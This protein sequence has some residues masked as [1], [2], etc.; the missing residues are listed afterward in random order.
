MSEQYHCHIWDEPAIEGESGCAECP[1]CAAAVQGVGDDEYKYAL[2]CI[3]CGGVHIASTINK[4]ET[5]IYA[6]KVE[7]WCEVQGE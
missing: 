3:H 2:N 7:A 6:C 5:R 1:D 4:L